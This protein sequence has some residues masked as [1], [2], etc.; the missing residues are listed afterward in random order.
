MLRNDTEGE[1]L[2]AV[3]GE[4]FVWDSVEVM[5]VGRRRHK[6][7]V[8]SLADVVWERRALLWLAAINV[9]DRL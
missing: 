7:L 1:L 3:A 2:R 6:D 9:L 5:R 4:P 8:I